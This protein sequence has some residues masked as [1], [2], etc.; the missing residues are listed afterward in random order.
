MKKL[1]FFIVALMLVAT[2]AQAQTVANSF[3]PCNQYPKKSAQVSASS[4][5]D[6]QVVGLVANVPIYVCSFMIVHPGGTG[7]QYL[8]QATAAS[9]G[10]TVTQLSSTYTGN[11]SAGS[12]TSPAY[13][14]M[15]ETG[16]VVA[17]GDALCLHT[18]GTIAQGVTVTYIQQ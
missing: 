16:L 3:D 4:A 7:T 2:A 13:P 18:T 9:C 1:G 14:P 5:T 6:T 15:E 11:T 12:A 8:E 10:G 17:A